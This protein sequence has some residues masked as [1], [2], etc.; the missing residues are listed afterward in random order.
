MLPEKSKGSVESLVLCR[1]L[2][3]AGK[4]FAIER[5]SPFAKTE[6]V[7][8]R[9]YGRYKGCTP[10]VAEILPGGGAILALRL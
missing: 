7:S 1:A 10:E 5:R 3:N 8:P 6:K 2:G 4:V 9:G